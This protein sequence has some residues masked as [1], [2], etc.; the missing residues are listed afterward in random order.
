MIFQT[1]ALGC[2]FI[3]LP[4][5]LSL[6]GQRTSSILQ[7]LCLIR[8]EIEAN[9]DDHFE[10]PKKHEF[11]HIRSSIEV[12]EQEAVISPSPTNA[13]TKDKKKRS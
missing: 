4:G 10:W 12:V 13:K 8:D 1:V 6:G 9:D 5:L 7:R 3:K 11:I 2:R